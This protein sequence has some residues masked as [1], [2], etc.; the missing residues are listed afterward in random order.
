MADNIH[1]ISTKMATE[2]VGK[3]MKRTSASAWIARES[4]VCPYCKREYLPRMHNQKTCGATRCQYAHK[5]ELNKTKRHNATCVICGAT[6]A[7]TCNKGVNARQTCSNE[8]ARALRGANMRR[9]VI[10]CA[11]CGRAFN[12]HSPG[13][14]YCTACAAKPQKCAVCGKTF[15]TRNVM[16]RTCGA[17]KCIL[18]HKSKIATARHRVDDLF[19]INFAELSTLIAEYPTMDCAECDPMTN[20]M[21][22]GVWF[23]VQEKP[24]QTRKAA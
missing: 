23:E 17:R 9:N 24:K 13:A 19:D 14:K 3:K 12:Q 11:K 18:A 7:R 16:Q 21:Q 5:V 1:K 22:N 6:F 20:R 2:I 10:V 4:K 8:C 15:S